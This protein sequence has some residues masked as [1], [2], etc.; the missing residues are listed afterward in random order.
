MDKEPDVN[1]SRKIR[2]NKN[3][4]LKMTCNPKIHALTSACFALANKV[5][6]RNLDTFFQH[7][8]AFLR[9]GFQTKKGNKEFACTH[10]PFLSS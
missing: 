7:N 5:A 3:I 4:G 8:K 10:E 9:A 2:E 6:L 1:C